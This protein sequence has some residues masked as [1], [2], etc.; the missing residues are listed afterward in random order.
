MAGLGVAVHRGTPAFAAASARQ[1]ESRPCHR[2]QPDSRRQSSSSATNRRCARR[3]RTWPRAGTP[4]RRRRNERRG[5]GVHVE[6]GAGAPTSL[7][8]IRSICLARSFWR[9][10]VERVSSVSAAKPTSTGC[11]RCRARQRPRS[12]RMSAVS[13]A[14]S[15]SSAPSCFFDLSRAGAACRRVVGD[16]RRHHD[17]IGASSRCGHHGACISRALTHP[18]DVD[19]R[20]ALERRRAQRPAST[21]APRARA[22]AAIGDSPSGRWSGC[23]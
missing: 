4:A 5:V 13:F 7:A 12:A 16:R 18:H 23:R 20:R 9:A 15:A 8:T 10:C 21:S 22:S 2:L 19:A 11:R 14:A 3:R 1:A 17:R 6:S